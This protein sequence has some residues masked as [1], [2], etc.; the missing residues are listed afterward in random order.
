[1]R[2]RVP[3]EP[4][5]RLFLGFLKFSSVAWGAPVAQIAMIRHELVEEEKWLSSQHFNRVLGMYRC[6]P[7]PRHMSCVCTSACW[8]ASALVA[9]GRDSASC[10]LASCSCSSCR[11]CMF[12]MA[13]DD[14]YYCTVF[15]VVQAAV[16]AL[17][18]CA[19]HVQGQTGLSKVL[20]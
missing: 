4:L 20:P 11:G 19:V 17:V 18:V 7:V 13:T 6:C 5:G 12:T 8:R 2:A 1:M 14:G 10:C 3:H 15:A 9:S 16:A